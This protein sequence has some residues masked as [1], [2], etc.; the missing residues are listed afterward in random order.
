MN[1]RLSLSDPS[2]KELARASCAH[3]RYYDALPKLQGEANWQEW[4]DAL[5]HAALMA[6]TDAVL[7]GELKHPQSLEGQQSTTSDWNDN[8]RRTA[9]WRSRNES[10]LKAIRKASDVDFDDLGGLNACRTYLGLKSKYHIT[11]HQRAFD[12]FSTELTEEYVELTDPPREAADRL[13]KAF[14]RYNHLV[15]CNIEQRL[16]EN[17]LKLTFLDSLDPEVYGDLR[18]ALLKDYNVL[19]LDQGSALAF[20]ELVELVIIGRDRLL[21][22]QMD[23]HIAEPTTSSQQ[24][25]KR[26]I[27]QVEEDVQPTAEASCSVPHHSMSKRL[28]TNQQCLL[29]NPR[30]RPVNWKA[31]ARDKRYLADHLQIEARSENESSS[32]LRSS[33]GNEN[34]AGQTAS[35]EDEDDT[36]DEEDDEDVE[37]TSYADDGGWMR[38]VESQQAQVQAQ[39]DTF[40]RIMAENRS[41][42]RAKQPLPIRGSLSGNWLLYSKMFNPGRDGHHQIELWETTTKEQEQISNFGVQ[43]YRGTL[44][45]GSREKASSFT[46]WGFSPPALVGKP[47][48][49]RFRDAN[50]R[51]HV[52]SMTFW[53]NGTMFATAPVSDESGSG[54]VLT[55]FAATLQRSRTCNKP[56]GSQDVPE[57]YDEIIRGEED[58]AVSIKE[59]EDSEPAMDDGDDNNVDFSATVIKAEESDSSDSDDEW[60]DD[61]ATAIDTV[62]KQRDAV[63]GGS[64]IPLHELSGEWYFHSRDYRQSSDRFVAI[65]FF[66]RQEH[67]DAERMCAPGHCK[68]SASQTRYCGELRFV[69]KEGERDFYCLIKQFD[70]P[71]QTSL[72][73]IRIE[74]WDPINKRTIYMSA[75]F[76]GQ[77]TMRM[78]IPTLCIRDYCGQ[79]TMITFSGLKHG[80]PR[81]A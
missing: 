21:Q 4:S 16:P 39:V 9:I 11:D 33:A 42:P 73:P 40:E 14:D 75:W 28:H 26:N 60:A 22:E 20:N 29:Q 52:G 6:G 81:S 1:V 31:S 55:D 63:R 8:V 59:E 3:E 34:K 68:P 49:I 57:R 69:A 2:V 71:K 5:Q 67:E 17:F 50:R 58:I 19:A 12:L 18:K 38:L 13:Q 10:L 77:G 23:S 62:Q 54:I 70:V 65:W 30:L 79:H 15:G 45:V 66:T 25:A 64:I 47:I 76:F 48:K 41:N 61:V 36:S 74:M 37:S 35:N 78:S 80:W 53:G 24:P 51:F 56:V 72:A 7:N 43:H 27:S 46:I 44:T 32:G